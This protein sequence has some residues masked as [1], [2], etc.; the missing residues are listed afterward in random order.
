MLTFYFVCILLTG[1]NLNY[2]KTDG[3]RGKYPLE[4]NEDMMNKIGKAV[5][6]LGY[7]NILIGYDNR[8]SSP[9]LALALAQGA[10]AKSYI[11]IIG[12]TTTPKL[13]YYS[14]I[15]KTVGVM[16]T[17]SH[18]DD[19]YNGVKIFIEGKKINKEVEELIS[20]EIDRKDLYI[21]Y[22]LRFKHDTDKVVV[23]DCA[24]GPTKIASHIL[25]D[26]AIICNDDL[27]DEINLNCGST[28]PINIIQLVDK[29]NA[30]IG[31]TFDGDGDRVN[32]VSKSGKL[33]DGDYL[34]YLLARYYKANKVV[35]TRMTNK[36]VID[37]FNKLGID[38]Y[39]SDV[40]DKNVYKMMIDNNIML[41][42]E[43]SGHIVNLSLDI[44]GDAVLNALIILKA[45]DE[46]EITLDDIYNEIK[47]VPSI[48]KNYY[49]DNMNI[50]LS[51]FS[52]IDIFVR[53]SGTEKCYR[54]YLQCD[55]INRLEEC[56][57]YIN[58]KTRI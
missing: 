9:S 40:G 57:N 53:K 26:N 34:C 1:D 19:T 21:N 38:V 31:F 32:A 5:S 33:I 29:Y 6:M 2:F 27:N 10:R 52:D 41:G 3:I 42:S 43:A 50:D 18:N 48:L 11:Y 17:A 58:E 7:N 37:A 4:I 47:I 8:K 25:F 14:F 44:L 49:I 45:L 12:Y 23:I 55:N 51:G 56:I 24:N 28:H 39:L 13:E 36:G 22:L 30:D 46:L 16:I 54:V 20:E 15:K 35:L